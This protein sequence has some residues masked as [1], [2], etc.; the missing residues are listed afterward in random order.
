L[1]K[2]QQVLVVG[3]AEYDIQTL[4]VHMDLC[5]EDSKAIDA[6]K[7]GEGHYVIRYYD[8]QDQRIVAHEFDGQFRFIAETRAHIAEW[9]GEEAYF[10]WVKYIGFPCPLVPGKDF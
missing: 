2:G 7:V 5:F 3:D 6:V 10:D 9:I 4:I 1:G 8:G